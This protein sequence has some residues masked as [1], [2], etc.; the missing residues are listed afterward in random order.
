MSTDLNL[1]DRQ[2]AAQLWPRTQTRP[3]GPAWL[4]HYLQL[5][6]TF[7]RLK[8]NS[9]TEYFEDVQGNEIVA[10]DPSQE[11]DEVLTRASKPSA[12][13]HQARVRQFLVCAAHAAWYLG[14]GNKQI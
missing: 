7:Q 14:I 3:N 10:L 2:Q 5:G 12:R 13:A 9:L 8:K 4:Y 1:S 6:R 11:A